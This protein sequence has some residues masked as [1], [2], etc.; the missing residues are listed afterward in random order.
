MLWGPV[1]VLP[2]TSAKGYGDMD[3]G[4]KSL[5]ELNQLVEN[6]ERAPG[7]RAHPR[8]RPLLEA[9]ARKSHEGK[10]LNLD[11][12]MEHLER[13]AMEGACTTYGQLAAASGVPWSKARTQ[14]NG[15]GG[16]LDRLLDICHARGLPLLTAIVVNEKGV[17]DGELEPVALA[18]F[19]AAARRLGMLVTDERAFHHMQ[20]DATWEWGRAGL[21]AR[22]G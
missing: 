3:F 1:R 2:A 6:Y 18:G 11:R 13:A 21:A 4:D 12:S 20:R 22:R 16:H 9:R 8:Y 14:M 5:K 10:L 17:A 19:V 7:G 15:A